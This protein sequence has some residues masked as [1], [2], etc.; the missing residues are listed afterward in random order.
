[1]RRR[2]PSLRLE[3]GHAGNKAEITV[4]PP[5]WLP[6]LVW[7]P[8]MRTRS[9]MPARP[10][11]PPRAALNKGCLG[12]EAATVVPHGRRYAFRAREERDRRRHRRGRQVATPHAEMATR[13]AERKD[14]SLDPGLGGPRG[15]SGRRSCRC[16]PTRSATGRRTASS[17]L[18]LRA[19]AQA[20]VRTDT[21]TCG[22][23]FPTH[24][25][26]D[27]RD[28]RLR[29]RRGRRST[30]PPHARP[31]R[32]PLAADRRRAALA[33]SSFGPHRVHALSNRRG[34]P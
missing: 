4:G 8:S 9:C 26:L 33:A 31:P 13:R 21:S 34:L 5:G 29:T 16:S 25:E 2:L 15:W 10:R 17:T 12:I 7:P 20:S 19:V 27:A 23:G 18:D 28:G 3:R 6:L 30:A 32:A 22:P 24:P 14:A 1:M 11:C